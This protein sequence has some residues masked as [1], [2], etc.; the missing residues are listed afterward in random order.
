MECKEILKELIKFDTYKDK[1]NKEIMDYIQ[2]VLEKKDFKVD[3][4]SKC[5]VMSIKDNNNLAILILFKQ[6]LIGLTIH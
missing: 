2:E 4:R 1:Q 5:L 3:Y 6:E